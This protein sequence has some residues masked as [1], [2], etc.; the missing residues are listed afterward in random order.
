MPSHIEE[1]QIDLYAM[2]TLPEEALPAVEEHLLGCAACQSH[3][4]ETD[5]FLRT[6]RL[7]ATQVEAHP[8]PL[9]ARILHARG[10]L[11]TAVPA[12]ALLAVLIAVV[13]RGS[14]EPSVVEMQSLRGPESGAQ[15]AA[16][17]P[18]LLVFDASAF[19]LPDNYAPG[20]K[21]KI[22]DISGAEVLVADAGAID[23]RISIPVKRL[24]R[25]S[26]WVRL[27]RK[28]NPTLAAEYNLRAE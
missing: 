8:V 13:P 14:R 25:G 12:F 21:I 16:G 9:W 10:P 2:G 17:K 6:F 3:L 24:A 26:Y 20:Y 28:D 22:L 18:L 27:Y 5:E 23:G 15:V 11:W 1:S 4:L 19:A 7:A